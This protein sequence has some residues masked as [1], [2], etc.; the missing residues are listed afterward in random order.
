MH[1]LWIPKLQQDFHEAIENLHL[2]TAIPSQELSYDQFHTEEEST[3]Y[4]FCLGDELQL[5][6]HIAFLAHSNE[7]VEAISAACVEEGENILTIRLASNHPPSQS[8][9]KKLQDILNIV[10]IGAVKR[11]L[12]YPAY[13]LMHDPEL[14]R[15]KQR[16]PSRKHI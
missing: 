4:S 11:E 5:A 15:H 1:N 16:N 6:N 2:G 12:I 13:S 8:T 9:V 14:F 10:S 3:K 7:G